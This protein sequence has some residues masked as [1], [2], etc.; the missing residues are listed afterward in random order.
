MVRWLVEA[1]YSPVPLDL[2]NLPSM[3]RFV[4]VIANVA[5]PR[6]A[7]GLLRRLQAAFPAPILLISAR[8]RRGLPRCAPPGAGRGAAA[9]VLPKPFTRDELLAA[10][11]ATALA[12]PAAPAG[13]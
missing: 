12:H 4:L 9:G 8:F 6:A 10:V 2:A 13:R 3:T 5:E 11:K 7:A 1:G